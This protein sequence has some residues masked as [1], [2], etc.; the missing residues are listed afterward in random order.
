MWKLTIYGQVVLYL[1]QTMQQY[2]YS[3]KFRLFLLA[4]ALSPLLCLL[5]SCSS[6][7]GKKEQKE[8]TLQTQNPDQVVVWQL[9]DPEM[10]N[11]FITTEATADNI[12]RI[13]F[14][15]LLEIDY[16]T[17]QLTPVLAESRAVIE[18]TPTGGMNLTFRIRDQ[19]RWANGTPVTAKDV[20]FTVKA[21]FNPSL[22]NPA[23]KE[24]MD[25]IS[26]V[27]LYPEDPRKVTIM[28]D[29]V[30]FLLEAGCGGFQILPE[31]FYDPKGLLKEYTVR[32]FIKEPKKYEKEAKVQEFAKDMFSEKRLRDKHFISG[33]GPYDLDSWT[34]NKQ[35]VV[36]KKE[37]YWG[38]SLAD[39]VPYLAAFPKKIVFRTINDYQSAVVALKAGDV[40]VLNTILA[41]EFVSMKNDPAMKERFNIYTPDMLS[42][43]FIGMNCKSKLLRGVKTRQAISCLT[44]VDK[45]I[46][47]ILY[48]LATPAVGPI[49][50]T[51]KKN[52]NNDIKPYPFDPTKARAL[53]AEDGWKDTNGDGILDK[54]IDGER[55]EFNVSFTINSGNATRKAIGLIFIEEA[56]KA[57]IKVTL[58]EQ[59]LNTY[60]NN[61]KK[62]NVEMFISAWIASPT[63]NDLK[64]IWH[65]EAAQPGGNNFANFTNPSCDSLLDA[66]RVEL[67][68][69]K[70]ADLWKKFQLLLHNEAPF[71]FLYN[72]TERIAISKKFTNAEPSV[73][74]PGFEVSQF[75]L[76]GKK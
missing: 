8:P 69:D 2:M 36:K 18:K 4:S 34:P 14:Q 67:N 39:K 43:Y 51:D 33:S 73:M 40:D 9:A 13:M 21:T 37:H 57:G 15:A 31:Y 53:L 1:H 76:S 46:Q 63:G 58:V 22:N 3:M 48:G 62:H 52:F 23:V 72:P 47:T 56:R 6:G 54:V 29:N 26:D 44:D 30:Y 24:T 38:D 59:E 17:L 74:R 61:L 66:I 55:C 75:K 7:T 70:R 20:E 25:F 32:Q 50:S 42:Y 45:I 71:V 41:K 27:K 64:P 16:K 10:L 11:P 5:D 12:M 35:V 65:T 68:E 60:L 28:C 19:A 49:P